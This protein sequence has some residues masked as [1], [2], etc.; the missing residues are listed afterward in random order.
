MGNKKQQNGDMPLT[1]EGAYASDYPSDEPQKKSNKRLIWQHF[2]LVFFLIN[3]IVLYVLHFADR[4][5]SSDTVAGQFSTSLL[6]STSSSASKGQAVSFT[7]DGALTKGAGT[8]AYLDAGSLPSTATAVAYVKFA[9]MGTSQTTYTTNLISY[10]TGSSPIQSVLTT[11][12]GSSGSKTVTIASPSSSNTISGSSIKGLTTLSDSSA[13]V[14]T[15]TTSSDGLTYTIDVIP[16]TL[17]DSSVSLTQSKKTLAVNGSATNFMTRVSGSTFALVYY[18]PYSATSSYFQ[19]VVIGSLA[20]DQTV[21]FSSSLQFGNAN[22]AMSTTFGRPQSVFNTSDTVTVPWFVDSFTATN[23]NSTIDGSVGLCLFTAKYSASGKNLTTQTEVCDTLF[24]PAYYVG[25]TKLSDTEIALAFFDRSNNFEL[26]IVTV[27][28][29]SITYT[30]TFRS[31]YV[32][33]EA[34]GAFDFGSAYGFYPEPVLTALDNNRLAVS[35][36]NPSNSGKPSVKIIKYSS[37]LS[38]QTLS[39][40][41]PISNADFAIASAD[42]SAYGSIVFDAVAFQDGVLAGF[43]GTWAG[44]NYKRVA[45]VESLGKPVGVVSDTSSSDVK[46]VMSGTVEA[47]DFSAGNAYYAGTD[48]ALY[49]PSTTTDDEYILA[50]SNTVVIA[51]DSLVGVAVSSKKLI[52]AV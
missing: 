49:A 13:V 29:S 38:L 52:V 44:T 15:S 9:P 16:A 26:T 3:I 40:A 30:P 37:D 32:V 34:S 7:A 11:V 43:S 5:S 14:L 33:A 21:S 28:F 36:L 12:T 1:P 31:S 10:Q 6:A 22:S 17:S 4:G 39:S 50:S 47:S 48:G 46:V 45:L 2:V 23:E 8:T 18:E 19:R 35:F 51:K 25:S 27:E 42:P 20:S 41:L 24:Q